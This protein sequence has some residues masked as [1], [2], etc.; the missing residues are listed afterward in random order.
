M[1]RADDI[2][3]HG[4]GDPESMKHITLPDF[5]TAD[6]IARAVD[7]WRE[8]KGTG[9]FAAEVDRQLIAPNMAR[10]N[11]ALGQENN[12][13]YLAYG[14]EAVFTAMEQREPGDP[15][16]AGKLWEMADDVCETCGK[17]LGYGVRFLHVGRCETCPPP[18]LH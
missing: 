11:A 2:A 12:A 17:V 8:L 10:I 14:V 7:L 6:E 16:I 4:R 18:T 13:R 15:D 1:G 9:R 3:E 5:L